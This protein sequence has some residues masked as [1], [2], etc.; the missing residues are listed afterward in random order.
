[1]SRAG[2]SARQKTDYWLVKAGEEEREEMRANGHGIYLWH[3]EMS[4]TEPST[5]LKGEFI[6]KKKKKPNS[7]WIIALK[8]KDEQQ[9]SGR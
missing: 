3:D 5:L 2:R 7:R 6:S 8:M 1:M 4:G 9:T